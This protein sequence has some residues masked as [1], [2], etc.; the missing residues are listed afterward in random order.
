MNL[1][2]THVPP[3]FSAWSS[4]P[5]M[6]SCNRGA[7]IGNSQALFQRLIKQGQKNEKKTEFSDLRFN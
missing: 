1:N 2:D 7:F 3:P 5:A 6:S 4:C